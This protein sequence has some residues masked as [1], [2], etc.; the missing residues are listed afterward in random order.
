MPDEAE[1]QTANSKQPVSGLGGQLKLAGVPIARW[2][3]NK[4]GRGYSD[5]ERIVVGGPTV[6][7]FRSDYEYEYDF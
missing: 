7:T 2:G 5:K 3:G 6:G 4:A 1:G